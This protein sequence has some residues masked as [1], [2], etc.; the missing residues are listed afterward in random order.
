MARQQGRAA[1]AGELAE[2]AVLMQRVGITLSGAELAALI[3]PYRRNRAALEAMR[4]ELS[5][6][7]EPAIRFDA[8]GKGGLDGDGDQ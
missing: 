4:A 6:A 8:A 1:A 7:E 2:V 3:E 5:Q